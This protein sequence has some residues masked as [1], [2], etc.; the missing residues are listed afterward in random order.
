MR[1]NSP[2]ICSRSP[3]ANPATAAEH[4]PDFG[5]KGHAAETVDEPALRPGG[6]GDGRST[7]AA[8]NTSKSRLIEFPPRR[9]NEG[10]A[11]SHGPDVRAGR[12]ALPERPLYVQLIGTAAGFLV[13]LAMG[14]AGVGRSGAGATHRLAAVARP[15]SL[16]RLAR[17]RPAQRLAGCRTPSCLAGRQSRRRLRLGRRRRRS[18]VRAGRD[19]QQQP[20]V[21]P[22]PRRRQGRL[23]A[24]HR[25]VEHQRSRLRSARHAVGRRRPGLRPDRERRSGLPLDER[26]RDRLAAQHPQGIQRAEHRLA[27]Q[28][29]ASRRWQLRLRDAW[30]A[31]RRHGRAR[32]DVGQDGVG[33]QGVERRSRLRLAD[34]RHGAR[35][36]D[37]HDADVRRRRRRPRIRREADVALP[38]RRQHDRQHDHAGLLRQQG[39]L[40]LRLR[41]GRRAPQ[42]QRRRATP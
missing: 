28:R 23:V 15:G 25:T 35:R 11:E 22:E 29:V 42:P 30:R 7:A 13:L 37:D 24:N 41:H 2:K 40:H 26:R 34:C 39:V 27:G 12:C 1:P 10:P 5:A 19:A 36:A 16:G 31:R 9:Y 4:G 32:Q 14:I 38:P 6:R 21:E 18:R 33:R 17:T 8:R 20:R 3:M